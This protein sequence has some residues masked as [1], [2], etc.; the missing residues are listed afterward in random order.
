M[1]IF[2]QK[3]FL[4][5][6][7][8]GKQPML[9]QSYKMYPAPLRIRSIGVILKCLLNILVIFYIFFQQHYCVEFGK[10]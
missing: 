9:G 8:I 7:G 5:F 1:M 3:L 6:I 4:F 10:W 2:D